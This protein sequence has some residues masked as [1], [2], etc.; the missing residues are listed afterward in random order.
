MS[1]RL[2]TG[3]TR[4]NTPPVQQL[5]DRRREGGDPLE[6]HVRENEKLIEVWLTRQEQEDP[7]RKQQLKELYRLGKE[8][9]CLV[10]V[11]LS[12]REELDELTGALLRHNRDEMARQ[13]VQRQ[14]ESIQEGA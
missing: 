11:F 7:E 1:I 9:H 8:K 3:H 2:K 4:K 6:V 14:R 13:E 12:G 5:R 10:A